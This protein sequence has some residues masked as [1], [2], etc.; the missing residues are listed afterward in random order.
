MRLVELPIKTEAVV[1][2]NSDNTFD[3]YLNSQLCPCRQQAA[4]EH[5]LQHLILEHLYNEDPV[6]ANE[7][8]AG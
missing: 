8:E 7:L 6:V 3:I 1:L 2:P 4:L 5:E